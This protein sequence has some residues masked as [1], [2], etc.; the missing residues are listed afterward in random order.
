LSD[1]PFVA[2]ANA[3]W[4]PIAAGVERQILSY[5]PDLMLVRVRFEPGA[6]GPLHH[7]PHRQATYVVAGSFDVFVGEANR[8]LHEGD[9]F[10]AAADIPHSVRARDGGMLIDC[11]TPAR[12]D[13]LETR[14]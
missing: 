5:G 14:D 11:F 4:K 9:T 3:P 13:F 1:Q 6:S 8:T 12:T 10:F 7:H 2:A